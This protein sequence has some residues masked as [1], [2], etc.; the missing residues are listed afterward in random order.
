MLKAGFSFGQWPNNGSGFLFG[1]NSR[2]IISK[3]EI[4]ILTFL[5]MSFPLNNLIENFEI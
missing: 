1:Y 5:G 4:N 2:P 3:R